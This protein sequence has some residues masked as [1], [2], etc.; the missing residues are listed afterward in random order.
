MRPLPQLACWSAAKL[1]EPTGADKSSRLPTQPGLLL[2]VIPKFISKPLTCVNTV[3]NPPP[4][5]ISTSTLS[6]SWLEC[7]LSAQAVVADCPFR[8]TTSLLLPQFQRWLGG[9]PE[10]DPRQIAPP[11]RVNVTCRSEAYV[12]WNIGKK[13]VSGAHLT[14]SP[15]AP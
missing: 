4:E 1:V 12:H 5:S 3:L 6:N 15:P 2:L 10:V 8:C 13:N 14:V 9:A 7:W 11:P